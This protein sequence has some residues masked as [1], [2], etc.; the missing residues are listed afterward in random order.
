MRH[1]VCRWPAIFYCPAYVLFFALGLTSACKNGEPIRDWV[2][3]DHD[4]AETAATLRG[5]TVPRKESAADTNV[6]E[7]TWQQQCW[8][9]H[10]PEGRG[11]GPQGAMVGAPDLTRVAWQDATSDAAMAAVILQGRKRMPKFSL[12]DNIVSGL[13][14]RIRSNRSQR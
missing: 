10:G 6:V 3:S 9:C 1:M 11:D 7:V 8:P 12:P 4:S 5:K 14:Q 13:V 2:S